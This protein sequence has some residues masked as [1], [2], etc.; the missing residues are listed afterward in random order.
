M[1]EAI[2]PEIDIIEYALTNLHVI[3]YD[4]ED[5]HVDNGIAT[6]EAERGRDSVDQVEVRAEQDI[7]AGLDFEALAYN[8]VLRRSE[9]RTAAWN[10]HRF[11]YD[12]ACVTKDGK[13]SL[14]QPY[15]DTI[16]RPD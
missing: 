13:C 15:F 6:G 11:G 4:E 14:S 10:P 1:Y 3:F 5:D 9:R 2:E 8:P 12:S 7:D 16:D